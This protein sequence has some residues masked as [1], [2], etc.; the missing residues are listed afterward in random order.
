MTDYAK[1]WGGSQGSASWMKA[2]EIIEAAS[3]FGFTQIE[4]KIDDHQFG[5][6]LSL[7]ASKVKIDG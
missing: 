3:Y 4:Y 5:K 6:A 2:E 7:V 1:F